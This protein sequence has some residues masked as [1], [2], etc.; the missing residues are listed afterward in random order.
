MNKS[1]RERVSVLFPY[2]TNE[3]DAPV[4]SYEYPNDLAS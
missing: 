1:A 2:K 3:R 4:R